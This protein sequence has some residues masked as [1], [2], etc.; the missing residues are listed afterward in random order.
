[1]IAD[2]IREYVEILASE[3]EAAIGA[4]KRRLGHARYLMNLFLAE[5]D[6]YHG[7]Q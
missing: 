5:L 7:G 2:G 6:E 4:E 1:M 3:E